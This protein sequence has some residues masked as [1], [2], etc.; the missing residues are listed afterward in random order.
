MVYTINFSTEA[1]KDVEKLDFQI[2][3]RLKKKLE[4][5]AASSD[6]KSLAK[7]LINFDDADYRLRVG[8]YRITFDLQDNVIAI[9]RI[10]HR[11]DVYR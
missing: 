11:K 10:R 2:K 9:V 8:D 4:E 5:I 7:R 1:K 3:K 6:V